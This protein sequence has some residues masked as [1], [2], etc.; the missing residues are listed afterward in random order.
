MEKMRFKDKGMH[1]APKKVY[2]NNCQ[3]S[4]EK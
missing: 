2:N 4:V 1:I 3:N